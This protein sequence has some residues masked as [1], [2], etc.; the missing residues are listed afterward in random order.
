[1]IA[2]P[3]SGKTRLLVYRIAYQLVT[4]KNSDSKILCLTFTNEAAKE[5]QI[6]LGKLLSPDL[7]ERLWVG[8]FH[9]FGYHLLQHYAHLLEISRESEIVDEDMVTEILRDTLLEMN[10][11]NGL[12]RLSDLPRIISRYR[13]RVNMPDPSELVGISTEIGRIMVKYDE[14]KRK[15]RVLDFDDLIELPLNMIRA[16]PSLKKLLGDTFRFI[17]ID[18]LQDTS[19]LQLELLKEIVDPENCTTFGVADQDQIL[20]EWRDARAETIREFI[21]SFNAE[22]EF[23][24]LNHR[25]P[26]EIVNVINALIKNNLDRFDKELKSAREGENGYVFYHKALEPEDEAKFVANDIVS[27]VT[28]RGRKFG[29]FVILF[30]INWNMKEIKETLADMEIPFCVIGDKSLQNSPLAKIIKTSISVIAG[31]PHSKSKLIK[32]LQ[33][34]LQEQDINCNDAEA[35]V[36][37]I[38]SLKDIQTSDIFANLMKITGIDTLGSE[39]KFQTDLTIIRKI[40]SLAVSEGANNARYLSTLLSMEWS[41]LQDKVLKSEEA[42][43]IMTIHQSKGLEFPVVYIMRLEDGIL[44]HK[45]KGKIGNLEEERRI[46]FVALSRAKSRIVM[47]Y[48]EVNQYGYHAQPSRFFDDM[49]EAG[50]EEI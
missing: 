26:Q 6:R 23:L 46:L 15:M 40:I 50:I 33:T 43:K 45:V 38:E 16:N 5:L 31:Q 42:V 30:R 22:V 2:G 39:S 29:D 48:S 21:K 14:I 32:S 12:K 10:E 13:G 27:E 1:V 9:Q 35:I 4:T 36:Q 3:G 8:N 25:S 7:R 44:P 17:F 41:R 34:F 20:Y 18:E 49:K 37:N 11:E 28:L 24:T 47:S 19:L